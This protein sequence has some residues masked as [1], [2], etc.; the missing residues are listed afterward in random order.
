M[1]S[2]CP[3]LGNACAML[4]V[5]LY[6]SVAIIIL[7]SID[8]AWRIAL[9][10]FRRGETKTILGHQVTLPEEATREATDAFTPLCDW[11]ARAN[12]FFENGRSLEDVALTNASVSKNEMSE[13]T[14]RCRVRLADRTQSIGI[15]LRYPRVVLVLWC[16]K[17]DGVQI[18]ALKEDRVGI[19][20]SGTA[21]PHGRDVN[22]HFKGESLQQVRLETGLSIADAVKIDEA[23]LEI[24]PTL[25]NEV[26]HFYSAEIANLPDMLDD[27]DDGRVTL[28]P[29]LLFAQ[30]RGAYIKNVI[31]HSNLFFPSG[32]DGYV[33][34]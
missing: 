12:R 2:N 7:F 31:F 34:P 10:A 14:M 9:C 23:T 4:G 17:N 22:G 28:V 32:E 3:T 19:P 11:N 21:L 20:S 1:T 6:A 16:R 33:T 15:T 24:D 18:L 27:D 5:Y 26:C 13:L 29:L 30:D 25:T 8:R